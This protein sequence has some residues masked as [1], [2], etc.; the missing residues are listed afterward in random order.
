MQEEDRLLVQAG[1]AHVVAGEQGQTYSHSA[2]K[3]ASI[4]KYQQMPLR[5]KPIF[6]TP[7]S[8]TSVPPQLWDECAGA[9]PDEWAGSHASVP[10]E[11]PQQRSSDANPDQR[12]P[13]RWGVLGAPCVVFPPS[14]K[15]LSRRAAPVRTKG[16]ESLSLPPPVA[17]SCQPR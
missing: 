9:Q 2:Q 5:Q 13:C 15:G 4:F 11:P 3:K 12:P 6:F 1:G 10:R 14:N 8:S 16:K 17:H 7:I